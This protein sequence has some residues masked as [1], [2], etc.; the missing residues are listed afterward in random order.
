[1]YGIIYIVFLRGN[2]LSRKKTLIKDTLHQRSFSAL[3][4]LFLNECL[5]G[6]NYLIGNF[7][8][9]RIVVVE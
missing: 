4:F 1:M 7:T 6:G 9:N 5:S 8:G 3:F 2:L